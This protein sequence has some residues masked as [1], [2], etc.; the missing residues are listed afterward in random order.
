MFDKRLFI[1]AGCNGAGK[2][3]ASFN[4]LPGILHCKEYVN[5]DEIA[6][7]ISPFQPDLVSFEA[8]KIMLRRI[9]DL[10][11][12][13]V[14]FVF[15]TTL[16]TRSFYK[17]TQKAIQFGYSPTLIFFWL[18]STDLAIKRV[19]TRVEEGGHDIPVDTIVRRYHRGLRNLFTLY[20]DV[21]DLILA[22]DNSK[23]YPEMIFEKSI[24]NG[25]KIHQANKY[26][27]MIGLIK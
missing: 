10:I 4:L 8:G 22:Y 25:L 24:E 16:S 7:G 14:D 27:T 1:I 20:W 17:T 12:D 13:G 23:S 5:A 6:R 3:T 2:T 18:E 15:E 9:D 26:E 19:K 11:N 21:F